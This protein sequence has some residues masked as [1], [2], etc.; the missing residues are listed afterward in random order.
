M[1]SQKSREGK[2]EN[3][4]PLLQSEDPEKEDKTAVLPFREAFRNVSRHASAMVVNA[5]FHPIYTI[6]NAAVLGH[7]ADEKMLAGLGLGSLTIGIMALSIGSTFNGAVSTFISHAYG[8]KEFRQCQVYRNKAI[9]IGSILYLILLVPLLFI[10]PI[11][12][13]IG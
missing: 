5:I 2:T 9:F 3:E 8:Q 1:S 6:V 13:A 12:A 10:R 11:Y 4:V 7:Q